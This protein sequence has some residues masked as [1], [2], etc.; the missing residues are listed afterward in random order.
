MNS[1]I[2]IAIAIIIAAVIIVAGFGYFTGNPN[3]L[4]TTTV[5]TVTTTVGTT[6]TI[7]PNGVTW[8]NCTYYNSTPYEG[9]LIQC[10]GHG[11]NIQNQPNPMV[12]WY[13]SIIVNGRSSSYVSEFCPSQCNSGRD[14]DFH[15]SIPNN[16][17]SSN[18]IVVSITA[19]EY[20]GTSC[21][22]AYNVYNGGIS[23]VACT[24]SIEYKIPYI[25]AAPAGVSA[26]CTFVNSTNSNIANKIL[27]IGNGNNATRKWFLSFRTNQSYQNQTIS[28]NKSFNYSYYLL[29]SLV[30]SGQPLGVPNKLYV[31]S[32]QTQGSFYSDCIAAYN[33]SSRVN[34]SQ[35]AAYI[36]GITPSSC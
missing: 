13:A 4:H 18:P 25:P 35:D 31:D 9:S 11:A 6:S 29:P 5:S 28:L 26:S 22:K 33:L 36:I 10:H 19:I 12:G 23:T 16:T 32:L 15:Y 24:N 14:I 34:E 2:T 1:A 27:C 21:V 3:S 8:A 17:T 7:L 20:N 30:I